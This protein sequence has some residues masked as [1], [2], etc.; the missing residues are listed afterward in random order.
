MLVISFPN[1]SFIAHIWP[2]KDA[3]L[4]YAFLRTF[5][6]DLYQQA[7]GTLV[8]LVGSVLFRKNWV[9]SCSLIDLRLLYGYLL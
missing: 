3:W 7:G 1:L 2:G 4:E 5:G 6:S 9:S 8:H